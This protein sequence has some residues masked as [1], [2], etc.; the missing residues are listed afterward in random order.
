MRPAST[1]SAARW[2]A[3]AGGL[4]AVDQL[5]KA[6]VLA[7]FFPGERL[8]LTGFLN[9]VLVFNKGAAFSFLAGAPGWQTP[10]LVAFAVGAGLFLGYLIARNR[11]R[12]LMCCGLSLVL[13]GAIGNVVDRLRIGA[14][15]DFADFHA[16]GW[17]FPTFNVADSAI[18]IGAIL[19]IYEGFI[20]PEGKAA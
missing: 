6:I 7:R 3:L 12:A 16:L 13:G 19:L 9:L 5:V 8:E 17:H 4:A 10:L 15:V 20:H 1:P 14:V 18:T 11:T 2:F